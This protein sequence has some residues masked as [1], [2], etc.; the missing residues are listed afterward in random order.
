MKKIYLD[1][2]ATTPL[3]DE[4]I[5]EMM[6]V[7]QN[8][9]GNPSSTHSFGRGAKNIIETSRKSIAKVLGCA[10]QEIIFTSSATEA[11][12]W[13]L[14][15]AVKDLNI[16][17]IITSKIEHHATLYTVK[18]LQKQYGIEVDYVNTLPSGSIDITHLVNLLSKEVKTLV[19]LMHVNNEIG[20][21]LD[22]EKT[23]RICHQHNAIFHCD[24]VQSIGKTEFN[25][26]ELPVDF[27]VASA[28]K[29][30]GPKG[31]GFAYVKKGMLLQPFLFGGEQ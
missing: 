16:K 3:R 7:L 6:Q 1:N 21:V 17:R 2:A 31:V 15:S 22:I 9:F 13:I 23:G 27:I 20:T 29:F 14:N 18:H 11:T 19:T 12:N 24:T 28:H 30:H 5:S 10:A 4:V 8:E 25:L 26:H